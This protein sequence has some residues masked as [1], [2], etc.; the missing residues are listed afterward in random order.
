MTTSSGLINLLEQ[1][2]EFREI[3]YLLNH[4]FIIKGY[5]S[6]IARCKRRYEE[7]ARTLPC[8]PG[9]PFSPNLH[10]F[11]KPDH[12]FFGGFTEASLHS[13]VQLNHWLLSII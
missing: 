5:N 12:P 1:F 3:F 7:R 11:T 9:V 8:P 13:N 10:K 2:T 6:G 4:C